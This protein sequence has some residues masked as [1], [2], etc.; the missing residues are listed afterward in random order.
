VIDQV[1][2]R[3]SHFE[4][5]RFLD[6]GPKLLNPDGSLDAF[7]QPDHLHLSPA[8]YRVWAD[9]LSPLLRR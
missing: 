3:L 2:E 5:V 6:L 4:N 1:N 7:M 8:G 9:E